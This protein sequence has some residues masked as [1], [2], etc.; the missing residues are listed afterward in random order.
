MRE[1]SREEFFCYGTAG[2][3]APASSK[4]SAVFLPGKLAARIPIMSLALI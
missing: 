1:Y 2:T 3:M 4:I